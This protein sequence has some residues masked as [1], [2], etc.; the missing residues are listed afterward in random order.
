MAGLPGIIV[1]ITAD[2]KDA[3]AGLNRVEKAVGLRA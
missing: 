1:K 2:V 3:V